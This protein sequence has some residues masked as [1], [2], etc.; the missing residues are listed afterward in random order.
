MLLLLSM[1]SLRDH[2]G[3]SRFF[4]GVCGDAE[5][6]VDLFVRTAGTEPIHSD[7]ASR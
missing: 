1:K 5:L 6:G 2:G 7:K 4:D 3:S